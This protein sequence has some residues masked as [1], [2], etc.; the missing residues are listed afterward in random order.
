MNTI[1]RDKTFRLVHGLMGFMMRGCPETEK[2]V[3]NENREDYK[4]KWL[5]TTG[6]GG[7][8]RAHGLPA[9]CVRGPRLTSKALGYNVI[10]IYIGLMRLYRDRMACVE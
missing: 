5:R 2:K 10:C 3:R 9:E 4:N 8:C 6:F 7:G 1:A